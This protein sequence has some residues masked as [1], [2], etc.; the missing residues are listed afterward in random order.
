MSLN[1]CHVLHRTDSDLDIKQRFITHDDKSNSIKSKSKLRRKLSAERS[2]SGKHNKPS[3]YDLKVKPPP[4]AAVDNGKKLKKA[5][6]RRCGSAGA[7]PYGGGG[8]GCG[9]ED[10]NENLIN[11]DKPKLVRSSGIRRDWSF[12]DLEA[13][14]RDD[15]RSKQRI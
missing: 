1:C 7:L 15:K 4:A 3:P 14:L 10:E 5:L 8:G 9:G 6:S 13:E 2:W 11:D 12:E